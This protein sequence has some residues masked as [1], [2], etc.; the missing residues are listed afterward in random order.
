MLVSVTMDP[1]FRTLFLMAYISVVIE[2]KSVITEPIDSRS[3]S[4]PA[5]TRQQF[6]P[7]ALNKCMQLFFFFF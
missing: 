2:P 6:C 7:N 1:K 3:A 4:Y 5:I